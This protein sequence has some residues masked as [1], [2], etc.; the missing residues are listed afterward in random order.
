MEPPMLVVELI[1]T[2]QKLIFQVRN[3][4]INNATLLSLYLIA[5]HPG[6]GREKVK[7]R[8]SV[9]RNVNVPILSAC[10]V[11]PERSTSP[12]SPAHPTSPAREAMGM[13]WSSF[14]GHWCWLWCTVNFLH[15]LWMSLESSFR[16]FQ[17]DF[18][19]WY[20]SYQGHIFTNMKNMKACL[21]SYTECLLWCFW[22][23]RSLV[24]N[25]YFH[26]LM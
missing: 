5:Y 1:I 19:E 9:Q 23:W 22:C 26:S 7:S 20:L 4:E 8:D 24:T 17:S 2:W 18:W 3:V 13:D 21:N 6:T 15:S 11:W 25:F 10:C 16:I 12:S 14:H